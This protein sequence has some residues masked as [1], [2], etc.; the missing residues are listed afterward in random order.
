MFS[1]NITHLKGNYRTNNGTEEEWCKAKLIQCHTS[2]SAWV[3]VEDL[4]EV[5]CVVRFLMKYID[6]DLHG[7]CLFHPATL[8][9]PCGACVVVSRAERHTPF[10][11][12]FPVNG[13]L[14]S[15][16]YHTWSVGP[17][18]RVPW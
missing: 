1:K 15:T 9:Q 8:L 10:T 4:E 16:L 11:P 2:Q 7:V 3:V 14:L 6:H 13:S 12:A 18:N 5:C 17:I